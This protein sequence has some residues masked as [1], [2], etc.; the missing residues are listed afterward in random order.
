MDVQQDPLW[1]VAQKRAGFKVHLTVYIVVNAFLWAIWYSMH[2]Q[3]PAVP[4]WPIYTTL[5]WGIGLA[6]NFANA[7]IFV[8]KEE[9]TRR[10]YEKLKN[11]QKN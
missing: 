2:S 3:I 5:G 8:S 1:K 4:M 9:M 11:A 6:F 7:Y 10:E